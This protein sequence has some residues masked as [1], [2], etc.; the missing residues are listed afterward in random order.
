M[1][2]APSVLS[3]DFS[4]L[5]DEVRAAEHAGADLIHLDVMDGHFVPNLTF[6]PMIVKA[7]RKITELP[8]DTH[9]MIENPDKY[10]PEFAEAGSDI[11]TV[12]I[13]ASS[14]IKRDLKLIRDNGKKSGITLNPDTPVEKVTG[15]F[16]GIDML[17][18]MSVFPGFAGQSF[19]PE[20]LPKIERACAIREE[21]GLDFAIE[22]DGGIT[23]TTAPQA[24]EAGADIL[25]AG[26]AVFKKPDYAEAIRVIR[27]A[28]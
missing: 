10:I 24:L 9:L 5:E 13:E 12:H 6:G 8:L 11:I 28:R 23:S 14:D 3:A 16:D 7:I 20:V 18:I 1:A 15:Y 26:S 17:L 19:M 22:I 4:K 27:E 2:I 25:V 21:K